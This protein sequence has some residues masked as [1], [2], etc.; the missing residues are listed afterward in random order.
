M[1][2][3]I[4]AAIPILISM[5][6]LVLWTSSLWASMAFEIA[7]FMLA[8][9]LL[10]GWGTGRWEIQLHRLMIPLAGM[11]L[12][13][14][15]QLFAGST[16]YAWRTQVS[17]LFWFSSLVYFFLALQ[18]FE[19]SS[20]LRG[21]LRALL[22]L[23]YSISL[24]GPL[25]RFTAP[26]RVF[27]L[28]QLD[29]RGPS[30]GPF[31]YVNQFAGFVE[32]LLP[33]AVYAVIADQRYRPY[34]MA[35]VAL[36]YTAVIAT[37]SRAGFAIATGT[38]ALAVVLILVRAV[39][40]PRRVI[41]ILTRT[42][43]VAVVLIAGVGPAALFR[44][45]SASDPYAD[46]RQ[47]L[48]STLLMIRDHPVAGVGLGN[49]ATVYPAYARFDDGTYVNQAR[50]DWAQWAA[51]GGLPFLAL[52]VWFA[53]GSVRGAYRT[54]W[55]LGVGAVFLHCWVDYLLDRTAM[56]MLFFTLCGAIAARKSPPDW[57]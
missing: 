33:I 18:V 1:K 4:G 43:I 55:G 53:A 26:E 23:G 11:A 48:R 57:D 8:A 40:R 38:I 51:E 41:I 46:R 10:V 27:W 9:V 7:G 32:L 35:G 34:H 31:L 24:L 28:F 19:D 37:A 42:L 15:L 20:R 56:A 22:L 39:D 44:K 6:I 12:W 3:L 30:W 29:F 5:A 25:Q 47:S 16:V 21:F 17:A 36:L 49:W 54:L 13:P 14:V 50:N 2:R 45:F 52:M